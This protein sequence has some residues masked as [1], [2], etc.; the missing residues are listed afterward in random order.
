MELRGALEKILDVIPQTYF[1]GVFDEDGLL[2]DYITPL[3][4]LD[5]E[6]TA[7]VAQDIIKAIKRGIEIRSKE[8]YGDFEEAIVQTERAF[9]VALSFER[10]GLVGIFPASLSIGLAKTGM[11]RVKDLVATLM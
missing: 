5:P 4:D 2:I 11:E 9:I 1:M 8:A 7:A 6:I 3:K 10:F